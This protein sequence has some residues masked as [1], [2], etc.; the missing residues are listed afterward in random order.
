MATTNAPSDTVPAAFVGRPWLDLR[1]KDFGPAN[2]VPTMLSPKERKFYLWLAEVW[3]AG[4]AAFVD[5][6]SFVGG[7]T[8]CLAQGRTRAGHAAPIHAF[9]RFRASPRVKEN[10]LYPA[11]IA[12][13]DSREV[14]DLTQHLLA[15]FTPPILLHKGEIEDLGWDYGAIEILCVDAAKS[16]TSADYIAS[17]FFPHL[18]P[19]RSVVVHQDYLHWKVPWVPAQMEW[20]SACF[21]PVAVVPGNTVAFLCTK[22]PGDADLRAAKV[23]GV[24]DHAIQAGLLRASARLAP[25]DVQSRIDRQKL[26][27]ELNPGARFAKGFRVRP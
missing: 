13:F 17:T 16:D 8:A 11:G 15:P 18:I 12:P 23:S 7:S 10:L 26:A 4:D 5:L 3:A 27:L 14:Y 6:G 25:W 20:L 19:G 24:A 21:R 22:R 9:D 1:R 2:A